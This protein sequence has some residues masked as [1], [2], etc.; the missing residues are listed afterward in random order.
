ML[1]D[2]YKQSQE[3]L[4]L[5]GIDREILKARKPLENLSSN[6]ASTQDEKLFHLKFYF[7]RVNLEASSIEHSMSFVDIVRCKKMRRI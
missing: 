5:F 3:S 2:M 7:L 4:S 6:K 1:V